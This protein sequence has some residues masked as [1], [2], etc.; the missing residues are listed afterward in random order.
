VIHNKGKGREMAAPNQQ[1]FGSRGGMK[2]PN[3]HSPQ[4]G[5]KTSSKSS[6][7]TGHSGEQ[8]VA[9]HGTPKP[10]GNGKKNPLH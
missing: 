1:P 5:G 8:G 3:T 10:V 4:S 6:P 7:T 9:S 2:A